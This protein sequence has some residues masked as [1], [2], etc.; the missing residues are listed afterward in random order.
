[1][2]SSPEFAPIV[3]YD[4]QAT[5]A[6]GQTASGEVDLSGCELVG[7]F[8]PSTFDGTQITLTATPAGG[9]THVVVQDGD[10]SSSAFTITTAASRYVPLDNLAIAAGIRFVKLVCATSQTGDTVFTLATRPPR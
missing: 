5:V 4:L 6:N 7:L 1:M 3:C 2:P 9:G 8:V 10:G